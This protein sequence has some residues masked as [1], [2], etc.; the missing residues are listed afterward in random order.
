[1]TFEKTQDP[2]RWMHVSETGLR[3]PD[4]KRL[5]FDMSNRGPMA[6]QPSTAKTGNRL[7]FIIEEEFPLRILI[8]DMTA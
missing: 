2:R 1:M 3:S 4:V 7:V 8:P 6:T 5:R